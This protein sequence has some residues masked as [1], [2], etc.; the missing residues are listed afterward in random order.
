[1]LHKHDVRIGMSINHYSKRS[2]ILTLKHS[3]KTDKQ[4]NTTQYPSKIMQ[5]LFNINILGD[6]DVFDVRNSHV[7][8][9]T[10]FGTL[11]IIF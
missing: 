3:G 10:H 7:A 5:I 4:A 9:R 11:R 1:M 8:V 2:T 6:I